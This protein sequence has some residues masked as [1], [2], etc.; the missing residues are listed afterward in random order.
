M[1]RR[2]RWDYGRW[3][4]YRQRLQIADPLPPAGGGPTPLSELLARF[5]QRT[6]LARSLN[7]LRIEQKWAQIVGPALAQR[8]RPG[9]LEADTLFV[10]VQHSAFLSELA[11]DQS[12]RAQLLKRL[13]E[14][15]PDLAIG[16]VRFRLD[17]GERATT[18]P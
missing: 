9:P 2:S 5:V 11:R 7:R 1:S 15:F 17:P 16:T 12:F 18:E 10:Y 13:Q 4:L 14:C 3:L 6:T 8:S